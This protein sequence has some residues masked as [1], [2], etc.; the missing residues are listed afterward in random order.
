[1]D[2]DELSVDF[3]REVNQT[4]LNQAT[5]ASAMPG[6]PLVLVIHEP[7]VVQAVPTTN[8]ASDKQMPFDVPMEE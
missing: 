6:D 3:T 7:V 4:F 5:L 1:M 2:S 8:K